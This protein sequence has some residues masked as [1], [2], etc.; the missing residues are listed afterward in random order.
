MSLLWAV[1]SSNTPIKTGLFSVDIVSIAYICPEYKE[2]FLT[3]FIILKISSVT[4]LASDF[5]Q[6]FSGVE[7]RVC[8]MLLLHYCMLLIAVG[9]FN[10]F[11]RIFKMLH[12]ILF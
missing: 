4:E 6:Y 8:C 1:F 12:I 5:N 3:V 10:K 2:T 11:V 7:M 9:L